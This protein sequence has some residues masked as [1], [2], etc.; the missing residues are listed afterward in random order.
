MQLFETTLSRCTERN[1]LA[2]NIKKFWSLACHSKVCYIICSHKYPICFLFYSK[3]VA[4]F[5][6]TVAY[7][8]VVSRPFFSV[9]SCELKNMSVTKR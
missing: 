9:I 7:T 5:G 2:R 8:S 1:S 6:A 4:I 3:A